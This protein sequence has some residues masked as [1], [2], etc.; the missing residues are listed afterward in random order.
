[1]T[2]TVGSEWVADAVARDWSI[3]YGVPARKELINNRWVVSI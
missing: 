3:Q 1:M 2:Y